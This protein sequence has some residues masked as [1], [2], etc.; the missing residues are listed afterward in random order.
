MTATSKVAVVIPHAGGAARLARCLESLT[1]ERIGEV[2]VVVPGDAADSSEA[3][4]RHPQGRALGT[5]QLL[6]F[7][8][9]TNLAA[10]AAS[11]ELLFLLNDDTI[12]EAGAIDRLAAFLDE[13]P[14]VGVAGPLLLNL[15][16]SIQPSVYSDPSLRAVVEMFLNPLI[17]RPPLRRHMSYPYADPP[18][19]VLGDAW[20]SGAA[21]MIRREL[22]FDVGALDEGYP[23]GLEDAALCRSVRRRGYG[24]ALV[25]EARIRHE[26]GVSGFRNRADSERVASAL[27][28]GTQGW[29]H[30]WRT[31]RG[32]GRA[33]MALLWGAFLLYGLSRLAA[34]KLLAG[35]VRG[36]RA[37][38]YRLRAA[39]YRDY[40]R[41]LVALRRSPL[42]SGRPRSG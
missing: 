2:L 12:A 35:L 40:V 25:R 41:S 18:S 5:P 13:A 16:G 4:A 20:V 37:D 15:D 19:G 27:V 38:A 33:G 24:V 6:S 11:G 32:A 26:G 39:A 34:T 29:L 23:H 9:A 42:A 10:S 8:R 31:V 22:Y 14:Q 36:P 1:G 17:R 30:Y 28:R 7:A 3:V 21:L